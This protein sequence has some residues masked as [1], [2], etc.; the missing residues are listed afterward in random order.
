MDF[1]EPLFSFRT[2]ILFKYPSKGFK[3]FKSAKEVYDQKDIT[4]GCLKDA[5]ILELIHNST[6]PHFQKL[7]AKLDADTGLQFKIVKDGVDRVRSEAGKFA[8][9][10]DSVSGSF[11]ADQKPCDLVQIEARL[12]QNEL[13]FAVANGSPIKARLDRA[14]TQLRENGEL[15]KIR[16]KWWADQCSSGALHSWGI[17]LVLPL[18]VL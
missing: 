6:L 11:W 8:F 1:T 10:T 16:Q 15:V 2:I 3:R 7:A 4:I 9:I 18:L 12:P 17:L 13:A 5:V 14:I